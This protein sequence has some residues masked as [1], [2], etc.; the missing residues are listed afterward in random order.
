MI[1]VVSGLLWAGVAVAGPGAGH[2][3]AGLGGSRPNAESAFAVQAPPLALPPAT[4]PP[5]PAPPSLSGGP[6]LRSHEVFGFAPWWTL[7]DEAAFDVDDL[8]TIAYFSLDVGPDGNI[9][10]SGSGWDGFDSE[11]LADLVNRAH[12]VDD[13]V[14]LTVTCFEQSTLDQLT[15]DPAAP[16][17]LGSDLLELISAKNLDGVNFDFEGEGAGDRQGLDDLIAAVTAQLRA[18][19][20]HWQITMST[21]AS[22]AGDP[23]GFF[24]IAGLAPYVDAFFVMAY[25][26]ENPASPS[27]TAPL[28]GPGNGDAADLD[29]YL[30]VVPKSKVILGVPYYGY[31]WPTT[32]PEPGAAATGPPSGVTYAQIAAEMA[33]GNL[34]TYWD[35]AAQTPWT[36]YQSGSQWHQVYFDNPTSLALKARLANTDGVAGVGV[37][38]LGMDGDSLAMLDALLGDAPPSKLASPPAASS[39]SYRGTWNST[40]ETLS[41]VQTPLPGGGQAQSD[42]QLVSFSTNDPRFACLAHG[43]ALPVYQLVASPTTYV[44][45]ASGAGF[46]AAGTWE[47]TAAG[48]GASS[49]T[50]SAGTEA[51]GSSTTTTTTTKPPATTTTSTPGS[52]PLTL[53]TLLGPSPSSSSSAS[54]STTEP[55]LG[56]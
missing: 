21:Y 17:R 15:S 27:P 30:R 2:G 42:G 8:T 51:S 56:L 33:A 6:P 41:V 25:D 14:V 11:A 48:A 29:Q 12:A 49:G 18:A 28:S 40:P 16:A 31:D 7:P 9:D 45:Q 19:D 53:P 3:A 47:F 34:P 38:A 50:S 4:A 43:A 44:V 22:S 26:M 10:E 13:R 37:W 46:C 20:P 35:T 1:A 5:A 32:G 36:A 24:D 52:P 39:Y 55:L 54:T 23:G